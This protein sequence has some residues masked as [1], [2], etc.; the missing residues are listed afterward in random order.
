MKGFDIAVLDALEHGVVVYDDGFWEEA[1]RVFEEFKREWE[2]AEIEEGWVSRRIE[3]EAL[4][5]RG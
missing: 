5:L 2:L 4:K 3:R 1:R